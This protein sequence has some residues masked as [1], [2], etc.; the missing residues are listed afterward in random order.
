MV[1]SINPFKNQYV[2]LNNF[3]EQRPTKTKLKVKREKIP[4]SFTNSKN[5]NEFTE[6]LLSEMPRS[7]PSLTDVS[8]AETFIY[9]KEN[10]PSLK[11]KLQKGDII[12]SYYP[13]DSDAV[14]MMIRKGQKITGIASQKYEKSENFVHA[15]IYS[16]ENIVEPVVDG[17]R[18][19]PLDG[20]RFALL[21]GE[22]R[23]Y[24][25]IRPKNQEMAIKAAD[26]AKELAVAPEEKAKH[27]YSIAQALLSG[28]RNSNGK[29]QGSNE[30]FL[31]A[32]F[33]AHEREIFHNK[34]FFC[35]Y[36][37]TWIYQAADSKKVIDQINKDLSEKDKISFPNLEKLNPKEKTQAVN[38]WVE[39]TAKK[40]KDLL[41]KHINL[42]IDAK[43]TSV[44]KLYEFLQDQPNDFEEALAIIA[45]TT[46]E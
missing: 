43:H 29:N 4:P 21:P 16:G 32:A 9:E 28:W 23:G 39:K 40:H 13:E 41:Q 42:S 25:V 17:V 1:F 34:K 10:L 2:N 7:K 31:K 26:L 30:R 44:R 11:D 37:V 20:E 12:L 19:N 8:K 45:P 5:K 24:L 3:E 46:E 38:K 36:F 6:K 33:Y 35:S 18:V 22:T 27:P 14:A 15:A